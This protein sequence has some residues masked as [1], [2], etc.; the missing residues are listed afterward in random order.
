M[1]YSRFLIVAVALLLV[2]IGHCED[3][4]TYESRDFWNYW[5]DGKAELASYELEYTRYGEQRAGTAVLVFVTEDFSR[6]TRVK[7][8]PDESARNRFPVMKLNVVKDFPTGVYDYN[9]MQT[10]F[11]QLA[12]VDRRPIGLPQKATFTSQEWCGHGFARYLF[13]RKKVRFVQ[14]SYFDGVGDREDV[15]HYPGQ[16][17]SEDTVLLWARGLAAPLLGPGESQLV[18]F[19]SSLEEVQI[20]HEKPYWKRVTIARSE[21]KT[22]VATNLG[23]IE[24]ETLEVKLGTEL[25]WRIMVESAKPHRILGWRSR[26]G[27]SAQMIALTRMPYWNMKSLKDE[28]H[29]ARLGLTPRAKRTM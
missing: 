6:R 29:L 2:G 1:H 16:F 5:G 7:A 22:V 27:E 28:H 9:L 10:A 4:L 13:E 14:H 21:E 12:E 20:Y 24:S 17:L 15:L 3:R 11:V 18:N 23:E 19:L 25:L 8:T 26:F